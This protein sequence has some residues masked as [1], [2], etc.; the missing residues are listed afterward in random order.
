L[1]VQ[2]TKTRN[3]AFAGVFLIKREYMPGD[4]PEAEHTCVGCQSGSCTCGRHALV[5]L[6]VGTE[7][8]SSASLARN[9]ER[10]T[11]VAAVR[12]MIEIIELLLSGQGLDVKIKKI[13]NLCIL[14]VSAAADLY[15]YHRNHQFLNDVVRLW[16]E[17]CENRIPATLEQIRALCQD[18]LASIEGAPVQATQAEYDKSR[19]DRLQVFRHAV[20]RCLALFPDSD[21]ELLTVEA[22]KQIENIIA[23]VGAHIVGSDHIR[24]I[25]NPILRLLPRFQANETMRTG[26][27]RPDLQRAIVLID[28]EYKRLQRLLTTT[29]AVVAE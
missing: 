22:M 17:Y 11:V 27:V 24:R 21:D 10:Q 29:T 2:I 13:F 6:E 4:Q 8:E 19:L 15:D 25:V 18:H 23:V 28:R 26:D 1:N 20:E 14:Q 7:P 16:D 5:A 12:Q 9:F 3:A